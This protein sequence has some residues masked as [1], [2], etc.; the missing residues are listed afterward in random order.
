MEILQLPWPRRWPLVNTPHLNSQLNLGQSQSQSQ[1]Y[2]TT[3]GLSPI[4]SSWQQPLETHGQQL[5]L[6]LNTCV[7]LS[8]TRGWVC[9]LQ[10][11]LVLASAVILKS[12]SRRTHNH[13]L[14]SQLRDTS[15][16][17]VQVPVFISPGPWWPSYIP[18]HWVPFSSPST[19][20]RATVEA[21]DPAYNISRRTTENTISILVVQQYLDPYIET[22]V[23]L[24]AY[25]IA[26]AL[27]VRFEV[28]TQQR[29]YA[30]Q[31]IHSHWIKLTFY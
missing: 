15:N 14:L 26:T 23:R 1:S 12:E 5:F 11:L 7:T 16:L 8:L 3:G 6:Q 9:R 27:L 17:E 2:F 21:F 29:V 24:S 18:K 25:C 20:R 22:D 13:I 28:S 19:T 4:S 31:Y 30:P 10:L